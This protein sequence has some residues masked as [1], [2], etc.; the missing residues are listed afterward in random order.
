MEALHGIGGRRSL[1]G[2]AAAKSSGLGDSR[3]GG[4]KSERLENHHG[5]GERRVSNGKKEQGAYWTLVLGRSENK[6]RTAPVY[7]CSCSVVSQERKKGGYFYCSAFGYG[8]SPNAK[9]VQSMME[10]HPLEGGQT[11]IL[12]GIGC[13]IASGEGPA[14]SRCQRATGGPAFGVLRDPKQHTVPVKA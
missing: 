6:D 11:E 4:E 2:A 7:F 3:K 9:P 10:Y 1:D 8:H 5:A 14:N 13:D 12:L